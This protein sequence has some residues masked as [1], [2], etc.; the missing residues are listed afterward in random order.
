MGRSEPAWWEGKKDILTETFN[1]SPQGQSRGWGH[2]PSVVHFGLRINSTS[3]LLLF[4]LESFLVL[5]VV[6]KMGVVITTD[7]IVVSFEWENWRSLMNNRSL[8]HC[9]FILFYHRPLHLLWLGRKGIPISDS[10]ATVPRE[11]VEFFSVHPGLLGLKTTRRALPQA[12]LLT[13]KISMTTSLQRPSVGRT[14]HPVL[15]R[16]YLCTS[17]FDRRGTESQRSWDLT[18]SREQRSGRNRTPTPAS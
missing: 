7:A 10:S 6:G 8:T 1:L 11:S 3:S 12:P 18:S 14:H 17:P 15:Y 13:W 5:A 4:L 2:Q 16:H 9:I